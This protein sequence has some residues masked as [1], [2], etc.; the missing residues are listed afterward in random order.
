MEDGTL[1]I[2]E[3]VPDSGRT[4]HR[5]GIKKSLYI[6]FLKIH[7]RSLGVARTRPSSRTNGATDSLGPAIR[8]IIPFADFCGHDGFVITGESP[9]WVLGEDS[10]SSRIFDC[11]VK[12][13]YGFS[14]SSTPNSLRG[15]LMS[16]GEVRF[17]E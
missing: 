7:H 5:D 8:R 1:V 13:L 2:Y 6:R 15:C 17:Q 16:V 11:T 3:V 12:P 4:Q 14:A 9:L 10:S